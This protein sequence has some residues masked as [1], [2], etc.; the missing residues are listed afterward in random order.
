MLHPQDVAVILLN[1]NGAQDTI[2]CLHSLYS[3]ETLPGAIIVVDNASTDN[4]VPR[5]MSVWQQWAT[6]RLVHAQNPGDKE[7]PAKAM[8]PATMPGSDWRSC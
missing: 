6:P 5:I 7:E 2:A 8:L 4:S 3:L 1:Y